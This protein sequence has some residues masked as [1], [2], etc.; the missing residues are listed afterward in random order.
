MFP[1][2]ADEETLTKEPARMVTELGEVPV[3]QWAAVRTVLAFRRVP[4]QKWEPLC[5][6]ETM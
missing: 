6:R 1:R 4:P 2:L 5:W 3:E